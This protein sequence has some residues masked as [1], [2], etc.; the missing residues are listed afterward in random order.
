MK[1]LSD[2]GGSGPGP[3]PQ[4]LERIERA[5]DMDLSF[6]GEQAMNSF[7]EGFDRQGQRA[8]DKATQLRRQIEQIFARPITA[9]VQVKGGKVNANLG[10]S[11][12]QISPG[13]DFE[14]A[15]P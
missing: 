12:P 5:A 1:R 15:M 11:M 14:G 10:K 2:F 6:A 3:S 7:A 13:G 9:R 8:L 4:A